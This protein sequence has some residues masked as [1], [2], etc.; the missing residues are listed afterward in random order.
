ML[1]NDSVTAAIEVPIWLTETDIAALEDQHGIELA[2]RYGVSG[3]AIT[4][5]ID[6]L[7]IRTARCTSS[8]TSQTHGPTNRLTNLPF[9]H[10]PSRVA[11]QA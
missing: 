7:Q 4:G 1:I 11:L 8:T 6:F 9:T 3:R 2:P 10:S 5:H